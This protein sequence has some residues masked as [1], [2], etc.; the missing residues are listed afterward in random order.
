MSLLNL[1]LYL[2]LLCTQKQN[3]FRF[4]GLLVWTLSSPQSFF[5]GTQVKCLCRPVFNIQFWSSGGTS[6]PNVA[7][8]LACCCVGRQINHANQVLLLTTWNFLLK[9]SYILVSSWFLPRW[10][11][12]QFQMPKHYKIMLPPPCLTVDIT[13]VFFGLYASPFFLQT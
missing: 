8:V 13:V 5:S 7:C 4:V 12:S 10:W 2:I 1:D 3:H 11:D 6:S 9:S